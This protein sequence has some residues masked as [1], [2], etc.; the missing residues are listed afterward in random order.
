MQKKIEKAVEQVLAEHGATGILGVGFYDFVTGTE[1]YHHKDTPLPM[2]SV[3]KIFLL[4]E[5]FR[6]VEQGELD[7]SQRYEMT[8]EIKSP[9][10]GLLRDLD[11]GCQLTMR[12]YAKLM[13]AISDNTAT[14]IL[15]S[16]VG[17][18]GIR[19]NVLRP[20]GLTGTKADMSCAELLDVFYGITPDMTPQQKRARRC[21]GTDRL[22]PWFMCETERSN[23]TTPADLVVMLRALYDGRW[24]NEQSSRELL[25]IME[26]CQNAV[27]LTKY[28]PSGTRVAHKTGS[29]DHVANDVGIIWT[30]KGAYALAVLYNGNAASKEEYHGFNADRTLGERLIAEVSKAVYELYMA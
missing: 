9:G 4:A 14:D 22:S 11:A 2:A 12:D 20:L 18:E 8:E 25:E 1:A 19:D 7:W 24:V 26:G 5:V 15:F 23:C 27:R 10:S 28:L 3:F 21:N 6:R 30:P 13:M 29:L 17:C 16:L